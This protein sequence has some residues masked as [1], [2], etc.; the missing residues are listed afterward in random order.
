VLP[1]SNQDTQVN[2]ESYHGALK[3]WFSFETKGISRRKIN[4]LTWRLTTTIAQHYMHMS[5]MKKK[6]F[7]IKKIHGVTCEIKCE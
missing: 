2:I 6:E 4:Y 7:I 1:Y 5:K 3:N